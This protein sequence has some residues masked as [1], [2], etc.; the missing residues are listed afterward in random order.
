MTDIIIEIVKKESYN[1]VLKKWFIKMFTISS[2][3]NK[4]NLNNAIILLYTS[5]TIMELVLTD[6][7]FADT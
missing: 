6:N 1:I 3:F 7:I 2:K 4:L 5:P